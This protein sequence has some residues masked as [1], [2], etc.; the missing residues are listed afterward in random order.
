MIEQ[1]YTP[2]FHLSDPRELARFSGPGESQ[3]IGRHPVQRNLRNDDLMW[4]R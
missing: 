2:E 3:A 1:V 4:L